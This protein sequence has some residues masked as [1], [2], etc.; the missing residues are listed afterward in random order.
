[1]ESLSSPPNVDVEYFKLENKMKRMKKQQDKMKKQFEVYT[2]IKNKKKTICQFFLILQKEAVLLMEEEL[3]SLKSIDDEKSKI[4]KI[5]QAKA[6]E[7]ESKV[8]IY[9]FKI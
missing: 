1:M 5:M 8:F 9:S 7:L 6:K 3:K 2:F 4:E